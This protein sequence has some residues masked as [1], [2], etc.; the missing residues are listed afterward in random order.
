[1]IVVSNSDFT[2]CYIGKRIYKDRRTWIIAVLRQRGKEGAVGNNGRGVV[3]ED[4]G[5]V[6]C[7]ADLGTF[8]LDKQFRSDESHTT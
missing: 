4:D 2:S 7:I 8:S 5:S 3:E 6:F 1:M